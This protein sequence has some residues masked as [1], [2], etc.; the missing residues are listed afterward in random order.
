MSSLKLTPH[1]SGI[2]RQNSGRSGGQKAAIEHRT[3]GHTDRTKWQ[4]RLQPAVPVE[5][6]TRKVTVFDRFSGK[7]Q[8]R[9]QKVGGLFARFG[10]CNGLYMA[11]DVIILT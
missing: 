3:M 9:T 6:L 5:L 1:F 11:S 7:S 2:S 10:K 8:R 4:N